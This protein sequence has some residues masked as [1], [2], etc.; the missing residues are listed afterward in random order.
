[1][2]K[3]IFSMQGD[4]SL[5]TAKVSN[6]FDRFERYF[7]DMKV[8]LNQSVADGKIIMSIQTMEGVLDALEQLVKEIKK[9]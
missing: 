8:R 2:K 1:M 4:L 9:S 5:T 6:R 3:W 7:H